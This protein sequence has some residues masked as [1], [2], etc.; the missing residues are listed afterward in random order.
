MKKM[1]CFVM[2]VIVLSLL[3]PS[4]IMA[5]GSTLSQDHI[6]TEAPERKPVRQDALS[7]EQ[8]EDGWI[9]VGGYAYP[10]EAVN[11]DSGLSSAGSPGSSDW[12]SLVNVTFTADIPMG[13]TEPYIIYFTN[14]DTFQEYYVELYASNG[15]KAK[16]KLP[17]GAYFFTGGGPENDYMSLY[18][19]LSPEYF[20]AEPGYDVLVKP[21]IR[22]RG[23]TLYNDG[24]EETDTTAS[25]VAQEETVPVGG[26]ETEEESANL[27]M[28]Y[29]FPA[30]ILLGIGCLIGIAGLYK[31]RHDDS[32]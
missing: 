3:R 23:E 28:K 12:D 6:E 1:I 4:M 21:V 5:T 9:L 29:F 20:T 15:Y 7:D 11:G 30:V 27:W 18:R 32:L 17:A 19:V 22:S 8:V 24:T 26:G 31:S 2:T 25:D 16:S 10:P 14:V 13:Q